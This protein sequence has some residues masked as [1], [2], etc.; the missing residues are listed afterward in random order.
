LDRKE[1]IF[2]PI[3]NIARSAPRVNNAIPSKRMI[4][5]KT[6]LTIKLPEIGTIVSDISKTIAVIG[7]T[8][9]NDSF[10]LIKKLFF[11][12]ITQGKIFK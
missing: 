1:P 10:I 7:S 5:Q 9:N 3:G 4:A 11:I 2:W 12:L 8:A 6:N